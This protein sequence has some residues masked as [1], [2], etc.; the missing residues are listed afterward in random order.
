MAMTQSRGT[1]SQIIACTTRAATCSPWWKPSEALAMRVR[2]T[3]NYGITSRRSPR[4]SHF[5]P[6]GFMANGHDIWFWEVGLAN[7][8]LVAGFFTPTD[9]ERLKFLRQNRR[10]LEATSINSFNRRTLLPARGHSSP[11]GGFRRQQASST[12]SHGHR[13]WQNPRGD[14]LDRRFP[15]RESG[16]KRSL[17]CGS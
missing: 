7:P 4:S 12:P 9:L 3:N 8:R 2:P 6:F 17:P 5:A 14:G 16:A 1:A 11:R 13:H 10:P 15:P